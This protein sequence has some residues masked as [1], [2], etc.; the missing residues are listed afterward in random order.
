[1]H[2]LDLQQTIGNS[3]TEHPE[4]VKVYM[5]HQVDFCCGGDR[6]VSEALEKDGADLEAVLREA[7]EA[8]AAAGTGAAAGPGVVLLSDLTSG[9]L[10]DRI[11]GRHHAFLKRELPVL[12]ELLS[13]I[14]KVHGHRHEELYE[15]HKVFRELALEL[16]SHLVKEEEELFPKLAS[17]GKE[18]GELIRELERE[19]DGAGEALHRLTELTDHFRVPADGCRT[20]GIAYG[21]L[22]ELVADMYLHVH[23][24]NNVLFPRFH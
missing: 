22:Q 8:M 10:V 3:V 1:M 2:A 20:Y 17:G 4:L 23:A 14:L 24:E 11:V 16:E 9:E 7:E 19:H 13:T 18:C 15:I 5:D 6:T 21:K 12:R